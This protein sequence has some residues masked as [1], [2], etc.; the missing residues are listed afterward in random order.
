LVGGACSVDGPLNLCRAREMNPCEDVPVVVRHHLFND[1]A[2]PDL[3]S[4]DDAR[5]L[6]DLATLTVDLRLKRVAFR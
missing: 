1:V 5:N 3:L 2:G 6:E 4:R